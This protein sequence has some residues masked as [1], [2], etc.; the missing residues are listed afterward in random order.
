MYNILYMYFIQ[1]TSKDVNLVILCLTYAERSG[2]VARSV[3]TQAPQLQRVG[4]GIIVS[5][6]MQEYP[7]TYTLYLIAIRICSDSYI[8]LHA[9]YRYLHQPVHGS[10]CRYVYY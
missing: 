5:S 4:Q 9:K 7:V 1:A 10:Q 8:Q 2:K 3:H 6:T